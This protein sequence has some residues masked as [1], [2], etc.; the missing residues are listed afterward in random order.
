[1]MPV[2]CLKP[3]D[4]T[5]QQGGY[6]ACDP[7]AFAEDPFSSIDS[8]EVPRPKGRKVSIIAMHKQGWLCVALD[9]PRAL[10]QSL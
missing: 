1:M 5:S 9:N 8:E 10:V 2:E 7:A 6:A 4:I 3:L